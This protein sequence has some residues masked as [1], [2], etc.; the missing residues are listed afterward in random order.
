MV[1]K[2]STCWNIFWHA[3][4]IWTWCKM[5][6]IWRKKHI[7]KF[8]NLSKKFEC[9]QK[10]LNVFKIFWM[11]SKFFEQSRWTGHKR[12]HLGLCE[13]I[14]CTVLFCNLLWCMS[15]YLGIMISDFTSENLQRHFFIVVWRG[16][17][18]LRASESLMRK[19]AV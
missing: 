6:R 14:S 17:G 7:Q 13:I 18:Y 8:L 3:L 10:F 11:N 19:S 12:G 5:E 9:I 1:Q 15:I 16:R 2:I 4:K